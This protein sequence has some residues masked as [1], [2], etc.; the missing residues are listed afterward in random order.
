MM[1]STSALGPDGDPK[2]RAYEVTQEVTAR[3]FILY[4]N[5]EFE[6]GIPSNQKIIL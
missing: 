4:I 5:Y 1:S 2:L 6:C 3:N